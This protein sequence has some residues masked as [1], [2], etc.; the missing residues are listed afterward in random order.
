MAR[1]INN[2]INDVHCELMQFLLEMWVRENMWFLL[3]ISYCYVTKCRLAAE[4]LVFLVMERRICWTERERE[5]HFRRRRRKKL[6]WTIC[7]SSKELHA[8][9]CKTHTMWLWLS[10]VYVAISLQISKLRS[11]LKAFK[12]LSG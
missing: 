3:G 5:F 6:D 11:L 10:Y 7:R 8:A 4:L 12:L 1:E 2:T 9:S